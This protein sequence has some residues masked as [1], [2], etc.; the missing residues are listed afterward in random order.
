MSILDELERAAEEAWER[1]VDRLLAYAEV[2]G[3]FNDALASAARWL[4][5][6][7]RAETELTKAEDASRAADLALEDAKLKLRSERDSD[8]AKNGSE[9]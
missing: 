2:C 8:L 5:E 7:D 4:S 6:R 1:K 9:S 3:R